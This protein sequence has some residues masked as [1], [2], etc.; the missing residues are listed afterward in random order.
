[1]INIQKAENAIFNR[2]GGRKFWPQTFLPL[3]MLKVDASATTKY[4]ITCVRCR[5]HTAF[6]TF[7]SSHQ[8]LYHLTFRN[9]SA[10]KA[11]YMMFV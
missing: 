1:M 3:K 11:V 5:C 7:S 2:R 10:R 4:I 9:V 8:I 6:L